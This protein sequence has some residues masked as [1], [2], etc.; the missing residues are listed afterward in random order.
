MS[1]HKAGNEWQWT[2]IHKCG[3]RTNQAV[4]GGV[5][6]IKAEQALRGKVCP[7]CNLADLLSETYGNAARPD[8]EAVR[9]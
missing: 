2:Q 6:P 9:P 4:Y 5:K 3:H 7:R 1:I 8:I